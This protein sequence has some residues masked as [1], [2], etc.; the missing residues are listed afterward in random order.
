MSAL[1][2][3]RNCWCGDVHGVEETILLDFDHLETIEQAEVLG[4][5]EQQ[6]A[7]ESRDHQ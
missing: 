1:H 5:Y 4:P 2:S 3:Q 7:E 6:F